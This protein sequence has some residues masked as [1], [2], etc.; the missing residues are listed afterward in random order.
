MFVDLCVQ[1]SSKKKFNFFVFIF[2]DQTFEPDFNRCCHYHMILIVTQMV[3]GSL[4][5]IYNI[6]ES[7]QQESR[8]KEL[9]QSRK[10]YQKSSR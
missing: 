2:K 4:K 5:N 1:E 3:H 9:L 6:D 8:Q 10:Q 7:L